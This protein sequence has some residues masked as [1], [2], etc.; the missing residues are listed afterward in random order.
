MVFFDKFILN[1]DETNLY[2]RNN[3]ISSKQKIIH[4]AMRLW[5]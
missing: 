4:R 2:S 1:I 5:L 3:L